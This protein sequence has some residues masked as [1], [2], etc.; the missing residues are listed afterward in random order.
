MKIERG[1][2]VLVD[3][4]VL[5]EATDYADFCESNSNGRSQTD[6]CMN[7][8]LRFLAISTLNQSVK[9]A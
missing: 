5:L 7:F 9:S 6:R 3:T 2:K 4:N 1:S 8:N